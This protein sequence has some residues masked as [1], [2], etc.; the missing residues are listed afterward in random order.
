MVRLGWGNY[1]RKRGWMPTSPS[2]TTLLK[3][4]P[5]QLNAHS[6]QLN[7]TMGH[8]G[9]ELLA[10]TLG[11]DHFTFRLLVDEAESAYFEG[12]FA[13]A[14]RKDLEVAGGRFA[15]HRPDG[16]KPKNRS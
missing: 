3:R 16:R 13:V 4:F 8:H 9:T 14:P 7:A 5:E 6:E 10:F 12:G 11:S 2:R 15:R 1:A